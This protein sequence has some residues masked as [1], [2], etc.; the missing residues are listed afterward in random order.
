[1][2]FHFLPGTEIKEDGGRELQ[3]LVSTLKYTWVKYHNSIIVKAY[4]MLTMICPP[5]GDIKSGSPL[6]ATQ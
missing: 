5:D 6:D 2:N 3:L 1:M 4:V